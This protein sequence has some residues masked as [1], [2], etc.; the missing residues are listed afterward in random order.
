MC[1]SSTDIVFSCDCPPPKSC[2]Q[3]PC[4]VTP[5]GR[6]AQ[7]WILFSLPI[8]ILLLLFGSIVVFQIG[9]PGL[10]KVTRRHV[11]KTFYFAEKIAIFFIILF[12]LTISGFMVSSI[13]YMFPALWQ[14][15]IKIIQDYVIPASIVL[16]F[17]LAV[18]IFV[19]VVYILKNFG[20]EMDHMIN[21]N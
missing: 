12:S 4:R 16:I 6:T 8:A 20:S 10:A 2:E 18:Y 11:W 13:A 1:F 19:R 17:M 21:V 14:E 7:K 5:T 3:V 9:M 15:E